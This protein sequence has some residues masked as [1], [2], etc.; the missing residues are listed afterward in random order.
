MNKPCDGA[1]RRLVLRL[2]AYWR[3]IGGENGLPAADA[4]NPGA[5]SDLW[6]YC[7]VMSLGG[8]D[9]RP[10]FR[11][12]GA[13]FAALSGG[14]LV[15]TA[16]SDVS[17]DTLAEHATFFLDEVLHKRAPVTRGGVYADSNGVTTLYRSILLPLSE[18][19]DRID[20]LLGA[21]NSRAVSLEEG[22]ILHG[23]EFVPVTQ[24]VRA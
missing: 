17:E 7:F 8:A 16:L 4:V 11:R 18:T 13:A 22:P 9:S 3:Q 12:V 15:G 5:I 1:E 19:G 2:L 20:A 24:S 6:Q 14:T 23:G 21:A 10:V